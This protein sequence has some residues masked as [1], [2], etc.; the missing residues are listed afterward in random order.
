MKHN[1]PGPLTLSALLALM[2]VTSAHAGHG[3]RWQGAGGD[4]SFAVEARVV[5]VEPLL[6]TVQVT[7]PQEVCWDEPVRHTSRERESA[8]PKVLGGIVGGVAGNQFGSGSGN[9]IMTVAGALLGA[10]IGSDIAR[11]RAQGGGSLVTYE[12]VC[13]IEQVTHAE[14]RLDGYRVTYEY[15]GREF[16]TRTAAEPGDTIRVRVRVEPLAYN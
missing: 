7:T 11:A 8:T 14:E 15:A 3:K 13:E 12:S 16:V 1:M 4:D 5:D 2:T 9:R 6:R 10:S